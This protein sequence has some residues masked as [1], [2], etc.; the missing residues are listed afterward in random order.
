[1]SRL[2]EDPSDS[3]LHYRNKHFALFQC[4]TAAFSLT[5]VGKSGPRTAAQSMP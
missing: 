5:N 1:V 4:I 3:A 2:F